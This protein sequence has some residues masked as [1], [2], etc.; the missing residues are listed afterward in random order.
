MTGVCVPI[1][2]SICS[3]RMGIRSITNVRESVMEI[4]PRKGVSRADMM[5]RVAFFK[6]L[7]G[8][9]GGLGGAGGGGG[10]GSGKSKRGHGITYVD[11]TRAKLRP[12]S[13]SGHAGGMLSA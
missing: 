7:V 11:A 13:S 1:I 2:M 5:K 12:L 10:A 3:I 4:L 9:D 8:F 6:D